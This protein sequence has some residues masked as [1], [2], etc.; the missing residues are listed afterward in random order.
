M[1]GKSDDTIMDE[2]KGTVAVE[3]LA[4][5]FTGARDGVHNAEGMAKGPGV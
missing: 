3:E 1:A 5:S 2:S 4:G